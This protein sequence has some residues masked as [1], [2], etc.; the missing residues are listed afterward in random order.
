[1]LL[2]FKSD[3]YILEIQLNDSF[4]IVIFNMAVERSL[5]GN[6]EARNISL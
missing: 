5:F 3:K 1:M 6:K 4:V 2:F